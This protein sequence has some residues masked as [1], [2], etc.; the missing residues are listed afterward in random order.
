VFMIYMISFLFTGHSGEVFEVAHEDLLLPASPHL[1]I[2]PNGMLAA[3][4]MIEVQQGATEMKSHQVI[5]VI[6]VCDASDEPV[7]A[8]PIKKA[9]SR[10][11][12]SVS[13]QSGK[14]SSF[15]PPKVLFAYNDYG[16]LMDVEKLK[17]PVKSVDLTITETL[18]LILRAYHNKV[19]CQIVKHESIL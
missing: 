11:K 15:K 8:L 18:R 3:D 4:S 16:E 17:R 7:A 10:R 13:D 1:Y 6:N 19:S 5:N 12:H 2:S 9:T 14:G